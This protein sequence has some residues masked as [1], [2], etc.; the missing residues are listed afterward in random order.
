MRKWL[1]LLLW[2]AILP[3]GGCA[4]IEATPVASN[5]IDQAKVT[6]IETAARRHGVQVYWLNYPRPNPNH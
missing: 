4:A 2:S 3:G 5:D 6:A 1:L